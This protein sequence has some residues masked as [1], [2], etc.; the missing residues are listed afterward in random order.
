[1]TTTEEKTNGRPISTG[2]FNTLT[3]IPCALSDSLFSPV[4]YAVLSIIP[5]HLFLPTQS[6]ISNQYFFITQLKCKP[7]RTPRQPH[8]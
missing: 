7:A 8:P 4:N 2:R 6:L 3:D 1:M 5:I